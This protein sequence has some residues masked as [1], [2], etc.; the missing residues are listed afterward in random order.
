MLFAS[1][2]PWEGGHEERV[3]DCWRIGLPTKRRGGL[4]RQSGGAPGT[5]QWLLVFPLQC[6][7]RDRSLSRLSSFG[8]FLDNVFAERKRGLS[9]II[10]RQSCRDCYSR[11]TCVGVC[12]PAA[13]LRELRL[14]SGWF[15]AAWVSTNQIIR[16]RRFSP[17]QIMFLSSLSEIRQRS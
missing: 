6:H 16:W 17:N 14:L 10:T 15:F 11:G 9:S 13:R 3:W 5:N 4:P 12:P 2:P 1:Y 8:L 7:T